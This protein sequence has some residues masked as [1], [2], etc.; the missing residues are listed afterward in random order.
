MELTVKSRKS[1]KKSTINEIRRAGN[2]PAILYSK[3]ERGV[4]L[5]V[6]GRE[7]QKILNKVPTGT[8][9]S[10]VFDLTL[11]GHKKKA[12]VKDIQYHIT[13]YN[14]IHL[15]F[16]ELF[17][18]VPVKLNIPIRCVNAVDCVGVKL[19]GTLRQVIR[20]MRVKTLPKN[21]P[22]SFELDVK[23]MSLGHSKRLSE[24]TLPRGVTPIDGLNNVAVVVS[25]K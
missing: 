7:F 10:K 8:L 5:E 20:Q 25:R 16:I 4:E 6:D 19:G 2:I 17:D 11:D 14:I 18:D 3:G 9:S 24:I 21:I 15:D 23:N 1:G 22:D 13:S 12:L